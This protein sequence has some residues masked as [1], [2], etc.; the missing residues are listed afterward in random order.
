MLIEHVALFGQDKPARMPVEQRHL[1][2]AFQRADLAADGRLAQ[3]QL[4][5]GMGEAAGFRDGVKDPKLVPIHGLRSHPPP[6][7]AAGPRR[8]A[9]P[10]PRILMA[11]HENAFLG[12]R[13]V[14]GRA[15]A[16]AA[17]WA[18]CADSDSTSAR[19]FFA[20]SAAIQPMPAAVTAWR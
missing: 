14:K 2:A 18:A 1:Q 19:Y 17:Y 7:G 15:A 10:S 5:A 8:Q 11:M 20:S 3:V 13:G 6:R 9:A 4:L 12:K 16:W